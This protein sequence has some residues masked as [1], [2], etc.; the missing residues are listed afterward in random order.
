MMQTLNEILKECEKTHIK[1]RN[2]GGDET[3]E[4]RSYTVLEIGQKMLEEPCSICISKDACF[5]IQY[6]N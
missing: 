4:S 5:Q 1:A 2:N 3:G 6:F